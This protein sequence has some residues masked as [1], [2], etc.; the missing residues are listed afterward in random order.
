[1]FQISFHGVSSGNLDESFLNLLFTENDEDDGEGDGDMNSGTEEASSDGV[2]DDADGDAELT[3]GNT[4]DE[5]YE[6]KCQSC[7]WVYI[8]LLLGVA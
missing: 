2:N 8:S 4:S 7:T 1:M 5:E 6:R 3:P